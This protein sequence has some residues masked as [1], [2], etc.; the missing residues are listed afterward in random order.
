MNTTNLITV[1]QAAKI[2]GK[3]ERHVRWYV[4]QGQ[5][6]GTRVGQRVLLLDRAE[7]RRFKPRPAGRPKQE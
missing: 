1:A 6:K 5:L 3:T 4:A 2:L 7:V